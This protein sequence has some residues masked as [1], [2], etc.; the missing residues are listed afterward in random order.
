[1]QVVKDTSRTLDNNRCPQSSGEGGLS[2]DNMVLDQLKRSAA[3]PSMPQ[4][5][6]RFLEIIQEP[7]FEFEDVVEVFSTD[8]GATS[9]ILRLAN[10]PL[11]GVTRQ[12]T[13]LHH[14][15]ILLG[16]K[17]VRSLVLGRYIVDSIDQK[18]VPNLDTSYYWRRSINT[19]V[20][21]ARLADVLDSQVREEAF[22]CGLL[23]DMGVV[24]LADVLKDQY[25]PVVAEYRPGGPANFAQMEQEA[26][27]L[28]HGQASALVLEY[29]KLPDMICEAVR[30]HPWE[31]WKEGDSRLGRIVGASNQISKYLCE[32]P[33]ELDTAAAQC[34]NILEDLELSPNVLVQGLGDL[35]DQIRELTQVLRLDV[36]PSNVYRL[37]AQKL[38]EKLD[39]SSSV[40][41]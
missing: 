31:T 5:A 24:I 17:R 10:S 18:S 35:E 13:S 1:M 22:V 23:A 4:V 25:Q 14:A 37:M 9:D 38:G 6:I 30:C 7:D 11:F 19:A 34:Q 40:V 39:E 41:N 28:T 16:L 15:L 3:I 32:N 26:I 8:P 33:G 2:V 12:I 20:L 29:W 21:A 27:G 36:P